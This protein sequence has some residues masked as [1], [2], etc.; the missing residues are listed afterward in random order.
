MSMAAATPEEEVVI[1]STLVTDEN[2][3][4]NFLPNL[5][6]D[7]YYIGES[8][9]YGWMKKLCSSYDGGYWNFY[10]L[11]NGSF[12]LALD[13]EKEYLFAWN[14]EEVKLSAEAAGMVVTLF[15]LGQLTA[16]GEG[17]EGNDK[18]IDHYY[19]L[20]RFMSAHPEF[21]AMYKIID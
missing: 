11:S 20:L 13:E 10:K 1:T 3:R 9:V 17:K 7:V 8:L 16:M 2:E 15:A 19:G 4:I 6:G 18:L 21:S 12:F 14:Y 5:L